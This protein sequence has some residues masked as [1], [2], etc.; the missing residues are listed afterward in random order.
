[1]VEIIGYAVDICLAL[2]LYYRDLNEFLTT[3]LKSGLLSIKKHGTYIR[4]YLRTYCARIK[5]NSLFLM[6][7]PILSYHLI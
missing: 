3:L 1:M 2:A 6:C 4:W 5:E 7:E